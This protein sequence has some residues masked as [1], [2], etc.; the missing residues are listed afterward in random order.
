MDALSTVARESSAFLT[1]DSVSGAEGQET[2]ATTVLSV[3]TS[4]VLSILLAQISMLNGKTRTSAGNPAKKINNSQN[5]E[6]GITNPV[7]MLKCIIKHEAS[8]A[9]AL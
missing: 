3:S 5:N 7:K 8:V 4:I 9:R 6:V 1:R 2:K